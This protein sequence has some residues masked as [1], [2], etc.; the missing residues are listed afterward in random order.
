MNPP[1]LFVP[2]SFRSKQLES[3][4]HLGKPEPEYKK[5]TFHKEDLEKD[6]HIYA[7]LLSP[8]HP[9]YAVVDEKLLAK[10]KELKSRWT[11]FFRFEY[12]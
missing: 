1:P 3:V 12:G 2:A 11:V 6:T 10:L 5:V 9:L 7:V 8:D 4:I